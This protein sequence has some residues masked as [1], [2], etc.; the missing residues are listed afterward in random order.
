MAERDGR[1]PR[2][3]AEDGG[4]R[5]PHQ[6]L[7]DLAVLSQSHQRVD[8]E[9]P[10]YFL[11]DALVTLAE[12]GEIEEELVRATLATILGDCAWFP[13]VTLGHAIGSL[14]A[15]DAE[16]FA[17]RC[18][19]LCNEVIPASFTDDARLVLEFG[20]DLAPI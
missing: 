14:G 16:V 4:E 12:H 8:Q 17:D 10:R 18:R 5:R 11:V 1:E 9:V 20:D 2:A 13:A 3:V 7:L 19:R 15:A 6:F